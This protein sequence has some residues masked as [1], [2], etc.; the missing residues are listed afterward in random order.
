MAF[1]TIL[2]PRSLLSSGRAHLM[3]AGGGGGGGGSPN[4]RLG[5]LPLP[6]L[7]PSP[8]DQTPQRV[9]VHFD[10]RTVFGRSPN[11]GCNPPAESPNGWSCPA[12]AARLSAKLT[13]VRPSRPERNAEWRGF[14]YV[15]E[16]CGS[17]VCPC[18]ESCYPLRIQKGRQKIRFC[19]FF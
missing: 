5:S 1:A 9:L 3:G 13:E 19:V 11:G 16:V 7:P 18:F 6:S 4:K 2:S 15:F 14:L 12:P 8:H 10:G 17:W